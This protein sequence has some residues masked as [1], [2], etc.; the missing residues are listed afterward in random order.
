[1]KADQIMTKQ[2][3]DPCF[4]KNAITII[5]ILLLYFARNVRLIFNSKYVLAI[6]IVMAISLDCHRWEVTTISKQLA[7]IRITN[8]PITFKGALQQITHKRPSQQ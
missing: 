7:P 8:L 1:M 4:N 6:I 3:Y 5:T 2:G